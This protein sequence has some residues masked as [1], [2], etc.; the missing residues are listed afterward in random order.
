MPETVL[1][2]KLVTTQSK[3][4]HALAR[5]VFRAIEHTCESDVADA[6]A[7]DHRVEAI[8]VLPAHEYTRAQIVN[9]TGFARRARFYEVI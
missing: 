3:D 2:V 8:A 4:T 6:E 9:G 7:L 5:A 1:I